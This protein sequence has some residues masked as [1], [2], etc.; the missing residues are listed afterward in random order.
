MKFLERLEKESDPRFKK[1]YIAYKE[2]KEVIENP[3][4]NEIDV[5]ASRRQVSACF[6]GNVI[7]PFGNSLEG[8]FAACLEREFKKINK[9]VEMHELSIKTQF[10]VLIKQLEKQPV[11]QKNLDTVEQALIR[12]TA[13]IK[14]L[15]R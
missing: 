14:L 4:T 2:L 12:A 15:E 11:S 8:R 10:P 1:C 13:D 6:G 3:I 7:V 9:F 5:K